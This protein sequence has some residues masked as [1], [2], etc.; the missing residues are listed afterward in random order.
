MGA[1]LVKRLRQNLQHPGPSD[2]FLFGSFGAESNSEGNKIGKSSPYLA[3]H[4]RFEID[5]VA[6]SMC[7]FGGGNEEREELDAYRAIHF[8]TLAFLKNS[9]K[10]PS[11]EFLRWDGQCPLTPEEAVLMLAALGFNRKT[12]IFLAGSHIYG[13]KSRMAALTSLYPNLVTKE[14]LLSSL[15][16][17]PFV[18]SSSQMAAL[19]FIG[20][21]AADAFAMT[22]SGSQFSS[23]VSGYRIYYGAERLPTIRPNK[24]RLAAIF[25]KNS[26]IEWEELERRIRKAI[27]QTK[28]INERPIARSVYRHPRCPQCM[29]QMDVGA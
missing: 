2:N 18:N 15:E 25:M 14:D 12:R 9:T 20:C 17:R 4:L 7:E 16:I 19:D 21:A 10:L 6:H 26:T 13:G 28:K 23:L 3:V 11:P 29:C 22:D 1:L 24:R 5:M 27:R 8:P